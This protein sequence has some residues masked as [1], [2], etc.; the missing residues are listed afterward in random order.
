MH[1]VLVFVLQNSELSQTDRATAAW[2]WNRGLTLK[3]HS[4][5]RPFRSNQE[6][7][8]TFRRLIIQKWMY[9]AQVSLD[10]ALFPGNLSEYRH[11]W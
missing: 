7:R 10:N 3:Q 5:N 2:Y 8:L 11:K 1:D 4:A 9:I 6:R